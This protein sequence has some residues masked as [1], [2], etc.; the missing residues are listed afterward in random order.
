M[1]KYII[2]NCPCYDYGFC[3]SKTIYVAGCSQC[4]DCKMK[5]IVELAKGHTE[6]CK[7]CEQQIK[8]CDCS[9]ICN[10]YR[11][12]KILKLLAIQEVE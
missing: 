5:Q 4:T 3:T 9:D 8:E 1:S 12:D 11:L 6:L 7:N 2:K 10:A